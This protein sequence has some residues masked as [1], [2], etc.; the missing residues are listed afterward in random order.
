MTYTR[1]QIN[2]GCDLCAPRST[3][4]YDD[5]GGPFEYLTPRT[6]HGLDH[7]DPFHR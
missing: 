1:S 3:V 4:V 5:P 2:E 6:G 7:L